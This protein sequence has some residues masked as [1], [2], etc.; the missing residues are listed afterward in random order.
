MEVT[1]NVNR[2]SAS[3]DTYHPH[4]HLLLA[5]QPSYF[6]DSKNYIKHEEWREMWRRALGVDEL[7]MVNVK[8]VKGNTIT[9]IAEVAK[10]AVKAQDYILDDYDLSVETVRI[11][12]AALDHRRFVGFGGM[13]RELH[14]KLNLSAPEDGDLVNVDESE[15]DEE[16][17]AHELT[18]VWHMGYNQYMGAN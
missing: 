8:R 18:F 6:T 9:A 3:F 12:D 10:Y 4:F 2:K 16:E 13:F 17:G 1:H 14:R 7:Y 5:V 15:S 11:L